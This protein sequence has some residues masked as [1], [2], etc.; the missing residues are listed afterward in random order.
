M[1]SNKF[2]I[3]KTE[4]IDKSDYNR[5]LKNLYNNLKIGN[6]I[7]DIPIFLNTMD[8]YFRNMN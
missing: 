1:N 5:F 7:Y 3:S 2:Y 4:Y 6:N 8:L